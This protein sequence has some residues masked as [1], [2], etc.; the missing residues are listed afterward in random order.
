LTRGGG[1]HRALQAHKRSYGA[2]GDLVTDTDSRYTPMR[3]EPNF[4]T[5]YSSM[6]ITDYQ[7]HNVLKLYTHQLSKA[8]T[9]VSGNP[10]VRT[11]NPAPDVKRRNLAEK[12]AADIVAR[13]ARGGHRDDSAPASARPRETDLATRNGMPDGRNTEFVYNVIEGGSG[14]KTRALSVEDADF[15]ARRFEEL[16]RK[17]MNRLTNDAD[18]RRR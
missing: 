17:M 8:E 6:P 16:V 14:K 3:R 5:I 12:I 18:I 15:L 2:G 9:A 1:V 13:I 10:A 7:M 11:P 4:N